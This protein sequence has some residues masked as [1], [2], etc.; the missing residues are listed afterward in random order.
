MVLGVLSILQ[1]MLMVPLR[2]MLRQKR[3]GK[4]G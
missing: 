3:R 1:R 2:F 4:I